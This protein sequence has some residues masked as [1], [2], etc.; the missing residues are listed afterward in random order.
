MATKTKV[1]SSIALLVVLA[2]VA[3]WV[4]LPQAKPPAL[5]VPGLQVMEKAVPLPAF[6]LEDH[7]GA[8]FTNARLKG[9]WTLMFFGYTH[10]PD[11]CPT[12]LD[13]VKKALAKIDGSLRPEFVFVTADPRR[14]TPARLNDHVRFFDPSFVGVTGSDEAQQPLREALGV[15]VEYEDPV[16]GDPIRDLTKLSADSDYLVQHTASLFFIDPKGRLVAYLLPPQSVEG[17]S[18]SLRGLRG[19]P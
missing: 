6:T 9:H 16:S 4:L 13:T 3:A 18:D 7:F 15:L 8:A 12:T 17:L 10:C 1:V 5:A 2:A 11:V 14:D 19:Q